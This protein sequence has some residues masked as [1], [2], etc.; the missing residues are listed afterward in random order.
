MLNQT[1]RMEGRADF[2]LVSRTVRS[3]QEFWSGTAALMAA[4]VVGPSVIS[5]AGKFKSSCRFLSTNEI[6][7]SSFGRHVLCPG[8]VPGVEC[9]VF[10]AIPERYLSYTEAT[11]RQEIT[12]I[13][14]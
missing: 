13:G 3:M 9:N 12:F 5:R 2:R 6:Q 11:Q 8:Y 4:R 1:W 10:G 14:E 7:L